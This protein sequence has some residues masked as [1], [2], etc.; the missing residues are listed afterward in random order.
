[1]WFLKKRGRE[2]APSNV[3]GGIVREKTQEDAN[4]AAIREGAPPGVQTLYSGSV[5]RPRRPYSARWTWSTHPYR[6][7]SHNDGPDDGNNPTA[8]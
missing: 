5:N 4:K 3:I 7:R 6:P 8:A 2:Q 1:M